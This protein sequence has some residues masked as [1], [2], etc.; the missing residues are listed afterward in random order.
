M[1]FNYSRAQLNLSAYDQILNDKGSI[2]ELYSILR[3][4]QGPQI[5]TRAIGGTARV[6]GPDGDALRNP[7]VVFTGIISYT[8]RV[9]SMTS[10]SIDIARDQDPNV[11]TSRLILANPSAFDLE[12][13]LN[14]NHAGQ[15]LEIQ[16]VLT[17]S[18][19]I[20]NGVGNIRTQTGADITITGNQVVTLRFD[21]IANEWVVVTGASGG[22]NLG[23]H[24]ATMDLDMGTTNKITKLK[25]IEWSNQFVITDGSI[26]QMGAD[27]TGDFINNVATGDFFQRRINDVEVDRLSIL[28]EVTNYFIV[29]DDPTPSVGLSTRLGFLA[30]N[31]NPT[32]MIFGGVDMETED[33]TIGDEDGS[34]HELVRDQGNL[35][36]YVSYNA[37]AAREIRTFRDII[38]S[39][40]TNLTINQGAL[41]LNSAENMSIQEV[42]TTIMEFNSNAGISSSLQFKAENDLNLTLNKTSASFTTGIAVAMSDLHFLGLASPVF[43]VDGIM[44]MES[45]DGHVKVRTAGKDV[46]LAILFDNPLTGDIDFNT[47]DA[48][49][50]DRLSFFSGTSASEPLSIGLYK[51][52]NDTLG[53]NFQD[54]GNFVITEENTIMFRVEGTANEVQVVDAFFTI[55]DTGNSKKFQ[56]LRASDRVIIDEP[57]KMQYQIGSITQFEITQGLIT[58]LTDKGILANIDQLGF[59]NLGNIIQDDLLTMQLA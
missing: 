39:V 12:T 51:Q 46:D 17:E 13:I 35:E 28:S 3:D 15:Y 26:A 55:L 24:I 38:M 23:N 40:L 27:P 32:L 31:I 19:T 52:A 5:G 50:I 49:D 25:A 21:S 57:D 43:L 7:D 11:Y 59:R 42:G 58:F 48:F 56:M 18:I 34:V 20:K 45:A 22:D 33:T 10:T 30:N 41:F 53:I 47:F 36:T 4:L 2:Q 9:L 37:D 16:G 44:W 29:K 14:A 54:G 6:S 1:G 8:P